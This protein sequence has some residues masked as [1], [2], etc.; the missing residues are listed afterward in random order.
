MELPLPIG[1]ES[2]QNISLRNELK[3]INLPW[4]IYVCICNS[5][6]VHHFG[7]LHQPDLGP[8]GWGVW[9]RFL[10]KDG[11]GGQ[12]V[13]LNCMWQTTYVP[14]HF[15]IILRCWELHGIVR[16]SS[17]WKAVVIPFWGSLII[18]SSWELAVTHCPLDECEAQRKAC[19]SYILRPKGQCRG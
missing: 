13:V 17:N 2:L 9:G 19:E 3:I 5:L 4:F 6:H 15:L 11:V 7:A 1:V 18:A 16:S 8:L 14:T 12:L 10:M